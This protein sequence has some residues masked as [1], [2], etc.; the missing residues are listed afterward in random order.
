MIE[1]LQAVLEHGNPPQAKM[2]LEAHQAVVSCQQ[3]A[4]RLA[5][6]DDPAVRAAAHGLLA[7]IGNHLCESCN[8]A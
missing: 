8:P 5:H 1:L 2:Q 6:D 4:D 3:T 7:A